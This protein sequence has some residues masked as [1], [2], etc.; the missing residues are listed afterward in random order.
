[1]ADWQ[2]YFQ[3]SDAI[4]VE[5]CARVLAQLGP[6]TTAYGQF[7]GNPR[8]FYTRS[9]DISAQR[10]DMTLVLH[11]LQSAQSVEDTAPLVQTGG[12]LTMQAA[13]F[14][15]KL[16]TWR[17]LRDGFAAIGCVDR[18]LAMS[19]GS[20]VDDA[21]AAGETALAA[22]L[23][24]QITEALVA[25]VPRGWNIYLQSTRP[26]DF[27]AILAAHP[28]PDRVNSIGFADCQLT[29]LPA[30]LARFTNLEQLS[31]AEDRLDGA[32]L[33]GLALPTLTTLSLTGSGLHQL[34]S[35][36]LA[37]FPRLETLHLQGSA[38]AA[39]EIADACPVLRRVSFL[40]TPLSRDLDRI[41]ALQ[42]QRKDVSW[43]GAPPPKTKRTKHAAAK[44]RVSRTPALP[45]VAPTDVRFEGGVLDLADRLLSD[46]E[47]RALIAT[48]AYR[49]AVEIDLSRN[50]IG[51]AGV[52]H[53]ARSGA[54]P[55]LT[56]LDLADTGITDKGAHAIAQRSA[57]LAKLEHLILGDVPA[58]ADDIGARDDSGVSDAAVDELARS[59]R[60]P[61]L[62][63]IV[64]YKEYRR[65]N[66]GR[67]ERETIP[68]ALDDGRV[69]EHIIFHR[70]WP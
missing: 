64:R 5:D 6:V 65:R 30:G 40:Y 70:I 15:D 8:D 58:E 50:R 63:T 37:G 52:A 31:I 61:A 43:E 14:A 24:R 20:I 44:P 12:S 46:G 62:R 69:V 25:D 66:D 22:Q 21:E 1:M 32:A 60:L 42:A 48:G 34:S 36:D 33:R 23:R 49:D 67:E 17:A 54:F 16:A 51:D 57:G 68:I 55:S 47:V 11:L 29:A 53:L 38:I 28:M 2:L 4:T 39:L 56:K 3:Q 9:V 10:D 45:V 13:R 26:D 7:S 41:A 59:P 35:A 27:E 18:T 19:P